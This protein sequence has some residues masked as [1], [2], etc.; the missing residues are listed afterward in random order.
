M[1]PDELSP[2]EGLSN[3]GR[4]GDDDERG[5][6]NHID[7][8]LIAAAAR[9]VRTGRVYPLA[10]PIDRRT[11][12]HEEIRNPPL[13]L[14][15]RDGGDYAAGFS[16]RAGFSFA[17]DYLMMS[18][19]SGT[20]V[21]ALAHV[22]YDGRLYNGFEQSEV[23]SAGA[24]RCGIDKL[25]PIFTRGVLLDACGHAGVEYLEPGAGLD[26]PALAAIAE[27]QGVEVGRGDA[28][29][30]R[31]GWRRLAAEGR[32]GEGAAGPSIHAVPWLAEREIALIGADNSFLEPRPS[33]LGEGMRMPVHMKLLRDLGVPI[34]ELLDLDEVAADGVHE[35]LF[36]LAPLTVAGGVGSPCTP[37]AVV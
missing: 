29:L 37:L 3:W 4:W 34:V 1:S 35:F 14:M 9:L 5:A 26:G 24:R 22:W 13:H 32:A 2:W 31:T 27:A 28:L 17:D 19:H 10:L 18:C 21:D 25:G 30:I 12:P 15:S 36:V 23:T 20:H 6:P 8:D 33:G 11:T 7:A 16:G